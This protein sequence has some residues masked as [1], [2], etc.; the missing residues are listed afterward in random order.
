MGRLTADPELKHTAS[1]IPVASFSIAVNRPFVSKSTGDRQTDF[2]NVVAW[3]NQAEFV[4]KYFSK[5]SCILVDGRL[6]NREYVDKNGSKQRITEVIAENISFTGESK[7]PPGSNNRSTSPSFN[8]NSS[9]NSNEQPFENINS[10]SF[11][12]IDED[13]DLPF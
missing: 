5:G 12:E 13:D 3:R 9:M 7:S 11:E 8:N 10:G 1:N 2:F 6:E 4:S